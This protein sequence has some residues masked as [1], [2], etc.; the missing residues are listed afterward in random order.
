MKT[1]CRECLRKTNDTAT[2]CPHCGAAL[3][4]ELQEE[5]VRPIVQALHKRTNVYRER[6]STGLSLLIVGLTFVI[7]GLIFYRLSFKLDQNNVTEVVYVLATNSA[8][9]FVAMFGLF[10][11]GAAA[12][13]GAVWAILWSYNKRVIAHDVEEI[14]Q[15]KSL[16]VTRTPSIVEVWAARISHF[17]RQLA[18]KAKRKKANK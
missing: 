18:W 16:T 6:V 11:G 3:K 7:I 2:S 10:A 12:I 1:Y 15:N 9:F 17:F 8:E 13:Y 4:P 14:R 5:E